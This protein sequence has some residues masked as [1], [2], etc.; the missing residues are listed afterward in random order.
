M[1][2]SNSA[3]TGAAL[4]G[5]MVPEPIRELDERSD[6]TDLSSAPSMG[7]QIT[8]FSEVGCADAM[9]RQCSSFQSRSSDFWIRQNTAPAER[10]RLGFQSGFG[11]QLSCPV[12]SGTPSRFDGGVLTCIPDDRSSDCSSS[13][14]Q[15]PFGSRQVTEETEGGSL[16]EGLL[17][18][19]VC[20]VVTDCAFSVAVA[21][22]GTLDSDLIAVS[23]GFVRLT[24]Y[25]REAV[26]SENCRFLN[27]G[28]SMS[29]EQRQGLRQACETGAHF[30]TV[31]ANRRKSGEVFKCLLDLR[32][33]VLAQNAQTGEEIW[34]ILSV[35]SD[36]SRTDMKTSQVT[37]LTLL[38]QVASGIRKRL[39]KRLGELGISSAMA[40]V[41]FRRRGN[42]SQQIGG[43]WS[44][45]SDVT[46][47][48][49]ASHKSTQELPNHC[50][51]N[52]LGP[53]NPGVELS[54]VIETED[55]APEQIQVSYPDM[56]LS[57]NV[58]R[59]WVAYGLLTILGAF[60]SMQFMRGRGRR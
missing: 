34:V 30:T 15:K 43:S 57:M 45:V 3:A 27:A 10:Q 9:E 40:P 33:L 2:L 55:G 39:T 16:Y 14:H 17:E 60:L 50:A 13:S 46:W 7:R 4:L 32:G 20:R 18:A 23:D 48:S 12:D 21:D 36:V 26:I 5:N 44:L 38:R 52:R 29:D 1:D 54:G 35:Q 56:R 42:T 28:C 59:S 53:C 25:Q 19:V 49:E 37:H 31:L 8:E 41:Q 47:K 11:R 58:S 51:S 6:S 24:G 22:P